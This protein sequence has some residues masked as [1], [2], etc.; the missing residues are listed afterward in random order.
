MSER[1]SIKLVGVEVVGM[2]G[3]S[4]VNKVRLTF[5][6]RICLGIKINYNNFIILNFLLFLVM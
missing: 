2:G 3:I 1:E 4:L 5:D 6:Y